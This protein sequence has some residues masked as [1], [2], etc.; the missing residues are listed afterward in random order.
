MA[1]SLTVEHL[2]QRLTAL[3]ADD[4]EV[5]IIIRDIETLLAAIQADL[6]ELLGD[7]EMLV[8]NIRPAGPDPLLPDSV[9]IAA[10]GLRPGDF[11]SWQN[12]RFQVWSVEDDADQRI[13]AVVCATNAWP[14]ELTFSPIEAV[15]VSY[16]RPPSAPEAA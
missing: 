9:S 11:L 2:Q 13:L 6:N 7:I 12:T 16:P 1:T 3:P 14:I 5:A 8:R 10:A 15:T 4:P